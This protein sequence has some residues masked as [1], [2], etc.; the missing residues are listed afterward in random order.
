MVL[1][2][3]LIC[4]FE[5]I[6]KSAMITMYSL[7]C[8]SSMLPCVVT[9]NCPFWVRRRSPSARHVLNSNI[10]VIYFCA[11]VFQRSWGEQREWEPG[12]H[13]DPELVQRLQGAGLPQVW[14]ISVIRFVSVIHKKRLL[15]LM[16][17]QNRHSYFIYQ[18]KCCSFGVVKHSDRL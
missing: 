6:L 10:S 8:I 15:V 18:S 17:K 13:P 4:I 9:S 5:K 7:Y 3:S 11:Y 16:Q 14:Y 12:R 2:W 1:L